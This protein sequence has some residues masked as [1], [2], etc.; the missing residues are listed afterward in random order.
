MY[1]IGLTGGIASGKSTVSRCLAGLGA[2]VVDADAIAHAVILPGQPAWREIL[3]FFGSVVLEKDGYI[4][5]RK[6]GEIVFADSGKRQRLEA[7]THPAIW[8][9]IQADVKS[10]ADQGHQVVVLDVPL[11][12]ET[13]WDCRV[14]TVWVVYTDRETQLRRL[15]ARDG[16]T[17]SQAAARIASQLPLEE[18]KRR[19]AVVI[20]N[21]GSPEA[22]CCQVEQLWHGLLRNITEQS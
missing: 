12:F 2:P 14:D 11:L 20:D 13:G 15:I 21:S 9:Q 16:L 5:R 3:A 6:L 22:V 8:R 7:I 1:Q 4:D 18:K 10:A 17:Q 19:A